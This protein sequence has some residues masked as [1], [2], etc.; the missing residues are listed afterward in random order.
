MAK[1]VGVY[2]TAH[3]PFCYMPPQRWN[4]VRSRRSLREDVPF[5]DLETNLKKGERIQNGFAIL[6]KK[7]A[8][9]DP[10]VVVIIGNDQLESFDFANFPAFSVYVGETFD[11]QLADVDRNYGQGTGRDRPMIPKST[12][13]GHP[14]L[15]TAILTGLMQRGFDPAFSM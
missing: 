5:E 7:I 11:G 8:A 2:N 9:A 1:L 3:S 13:T 4:E 15:G 6:A 12:L 10:D 14:E